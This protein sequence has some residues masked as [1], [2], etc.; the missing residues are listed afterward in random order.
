MRDAERESVVVLT[1]QRGAVPPRVLDGAARVHALPPNTS[2]L[3]RAERLR[4]HAAK[5]DV[6]VLH[7]HTF[8]PVPTVALAAMEDRPPLVF[9]DHSGAA[10]W[11]SRS[12]VDLLVAAQPSITPI[13]ARHGIPPERYIGVPFPTSGGDS[14]GRDASEPLPAA[15]RDA[16][17]HALLRELSWPADTVLLLAVGATYKFQGPPGLSLL[18]LVG[19]VLERHPRA[20]LLAAGVDP[21]GRWEEA[22]RRTRGRVRAVGSRGD[23]GSLYAAADIALDS[24]PYG[25]NGVAAEAASHGLPVLACAGSELEGSFCH[26]L[27]CFG[28]HQE[29]DIEHYRETL[30]KWLSD[31]AERARVGNAARETVAR[32]DAAWDE[33]RER[34]YVRAAELGPVGT[35]PDPP[36]EP[37]P[38][39]VV[40]GLMQHATGESLV[41]EMVE[42][43]IRVL[44]LA[45]E[46]QGVR[47]LFD[48]LTGHSWGPEGART[49]GTVFAAP[50]ANPTELRRVVSD[51]DVLRGS[52]LA[53]GS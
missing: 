31:P 47:R 25:G 39:D 34:I 20:R 48:S 5:A 16:A 45:A 36:E 3:R 9:N 4:T 49:A 41:P 27:P 12:V 2:M 30:A 44:E 53:S 46:N 37:Q 35:L 22:A 50:A 32:H 52:E 43:L 40:V 11:F 51:F 42:R 33:G 14:N 21:A 15:E 17:R 7:A 18:D 29:P 23:L 26:A 10:F 19:P 6:V 38:V 28:A 1:R 8:D 24:F 13:V